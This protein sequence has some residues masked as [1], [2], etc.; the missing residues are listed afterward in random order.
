MLLYRNDI[1]SLEG[2]RYRFL[3]ADTQ[4]S[5]AWAIAL[6][7]ASAWPVDLPSNVIRRLTADGSDT[8]ARTIYSSAAMLLKRDEAYERIHPLVTGGADIY[9]PVTRG[10]LVNSRAKQLGC[11]RVTLYKD[12]RRWFQ[13]GQ[14]PDA[15][16]GHYQNSG[17]TEVRRTKKVPHEAPLVLEDGDELESSVPKYAIYQLTEEDLRAFRKHIEKSGGY[18]KDARVTM[19]SAFQRL[20]EQHY[21]TLDGNGDKYIR[22]VGNRP[23]YR[24]FTHFIRKH[25]S[26]EARLRGRKGDKD[27]ELENAAKL[28]TIGADCRGVGHYYEIDATIVDVQLVSTTNVNDIIGKPTLYLVI[29]RKSR[30]IVGFYCGLENASWMG[31][32]QAILSIAADKRALCS[33]YGVVYDPEDW[34]ADKVFPREFLAD[35]GE[36]LHSNSNNV[37]DGLAITVTNLPSRMAKWKPVVE[38][39]F[40]LT[41]EAL[42]DVAP[43]YNPVFNAVKR[44]GKHYDKD[45]CLTLHEFVGIMLRTIIAHNRKAMPRYNLS[46]DEVSNRVQPIPIHLWN[47]DIPKSAGNLTRYNEAQVHQALLPKE[48]ATVTDKGVLFRGCFYTCP[49]AEAR[50][51]FVLARNTSQFSLTVSFD[52]RLVDRIWVHSPHDRNALLEAN[53]TTRSDKF[54]GLSFAE[55]THYIELEKKMAPSNQQNRLQTN[56]EYHDDVDPVVQGAKARYKRVGTNGSR[57]SRKADVKPSRTQN[58]QK[59]RQDLASAPWPAEQTLGH[60]VA[61]IDGH[62]PPT[63]NTT[64]L[65]LVQPAPTGQPSSNLSPAQRAQELRRK[66]TNDY[67]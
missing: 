36:M 14:T 4:E 27:F 42:A 65:R 34:P 51:W 19:T 6:D 12:L 9:S 10:P 62:V 67:K 45:A 17:R 57:S 55:V 7:D 50:G 22:M 2:R 66:M 52:Y 38:C 32:M 1:F 44:Q 40:K 35:R 5:L 64:G 21:S 23:T 8:T 61:S 3:H 30:L 47:H 48:K 26:L 16:L 63:P 29:D 20:L 53:L 37:S 15:L 13:G 49:E 39:G 28:G 60:V 11:S 54:S 24:Q 59:E 58:R 46:L 43:S 56:S 25:Y 18:L 33:R 31:A 41:H